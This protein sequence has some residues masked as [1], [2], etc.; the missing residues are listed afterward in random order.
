MRAILP[1]FAVLALGCTEQSFFVDKKPEPPGLSPGSVTGRVCDPTGRTWLADA[2]VYTHL[3]TDDGHLYDT[4]EAYTDRD[5]YWT[6]ADLPA[7]KEYTFYVQY[8]DEVL[9]EHTAFV[10]N[11]EDVR[12]EEPDCFDPLQLDVAVVTG[13]YD[14][15]QTVL[16]NMGFA[17]YHVVDG[18]VDTEV[19]DFLTD[20]DAMAQYDIIFF[21]GGFVEEDVIYDSDGS[22][23]TDGTSVPD[24]VM[25]N[26]VEYVQNGGTIYASDWAY[27]VVEQGWPNRI[28]FVGDDS[29]PNDAQLGE[30]DAVNA[31]V[32]D[33]ALAE[34]LGTNYI[35]IEYDLPVWPPIESTAGSV[36]S[37]LTGS[38]SYR[39]GTATY[40]LASVPLLVSFSSGEGMVAF[41]TFRVARN[42][43]SD[44]MLVLQYMMYNL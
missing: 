9:E 37:H 21:N 17:N 34:W 36:T 41:S 24:Q 4:L 23:P 28:D 15:F 19:V 3:F 40:S 11:G 25:A 1:I 29:I 16:N 6:I 12:L 10:D 20:P 39:I 13:D 32:S 38:V 8:G 35:D 5:G 22:E 43:S 30:Y 18:Q 33:A 2:L 7:E 31:A 26:L 42:A 14:D 27:D 44:M